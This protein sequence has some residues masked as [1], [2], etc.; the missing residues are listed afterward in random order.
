MTTSAISLIQPSDAA[1]PRIT[2]LYPLVEL[3]SEGEP[4]R[5]CLFIL[6]AGSGP[7]STDPSADRLLVV[8]PPQDLATRF[9]LPEQTAVLSTTNA[10]LPA[11]PRLQTIA[12]G[13]AHIRLGDHFLDIYALANGAVVVLPPLGLLLSGGF[14]SD[15]VPPAV[16]ESSDGAA[17]LES[18]RLLARLLKQHRIRLLLPHAGSPCNEYAAIMAR[19]AADVA[20]LHGLRRAVLPLIGSPEITER[21]AQIGPALLPADWQN[22]AARAVHAANLQRLLNRPPH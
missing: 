16:A 18:L 2:Q 8:D 14:G 15:R 10:P 22:D 13:V 11:L 19:L 1:A 7:L 4:V 17:E 5:N 9:R 3:L 12:G 20:Y 21:T 6:E